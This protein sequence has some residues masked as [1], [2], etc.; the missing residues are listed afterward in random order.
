MRRGRWAD[1]GVLREAAQDG[2]ISAATLREIGVPGVTV[3]RRCRAGG[4]W[5]RLLPGVILLSTGTPTRRQQVRAALL[6]GGDNAILTGIEACRLHGVRRGP[7]AGDAVHL[8]VP[9]ARQLRGA[10]F[11][12]VERT[13]RPPRPRVLSGLPVAPASRACLDAARRLRSPSD[14]TELIAD[15]VQRR[16]CTV[17]QLNAELAAGSQRG[18][19]TP[20][21]VLAEVSEGVRSA[22]ERDAKKL[23]ARSGLP[24]AWWNARIYD[25]D[26]RLLGIADAWFDDVAL[27]WEINSYAYHLSPE[28]YARTTTR[29]AGL[30]AAGAVVVPVLPTKLRDDGRAAISDLSR[31]YN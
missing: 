10:D 8:L 9:H 26:D 3:A 25:A 29:A 22:A 2:V 7:E 1:A 17:A 21:R 19:A 14:I 13:T 30:T 5:Q 11:V 12:V 31:A 24:E 4:P 27:C 20:R 15:T 23:L 28:D 18:S 6:Y 16:L